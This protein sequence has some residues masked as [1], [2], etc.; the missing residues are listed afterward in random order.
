M[1][2]M[3]TL[4]RDKNSY[5]SSYNF[6]GF[7]MLVRSEKKNRFMLFPSSRSKKKDEVK[8]KYSQNC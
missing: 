7:K 1:K 4:P 6:L 5:H 8:K 3:N 2:Y